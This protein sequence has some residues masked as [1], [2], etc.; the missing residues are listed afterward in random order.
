MT[1]DRK[2]LSLAIRAAIV[3]ALIP[4]F[5]PTLAFAQDDAKSEAEMATLDKVVVTA[6]KR[7]EELRDVPLSIT[8]V[9][10]AKIENLGLESINDI[11]KVSPGFSFRSAFGREGDRPVIRGQANIQGEA[12]AAFFIDGVFVNGSISGYGLDNL[13]RVEVIRGPQAALFGRRTFA[14]AV[15]FI[16]KRPTNEPQAKISLSAATN[17]DREFAANVSGA[18]V[19]DLLM[20][21]ANTRYYQ[22]GGQWKNAV[23]DINDLGGQRTASVGG[24]L[25]FTPNDWWESTL[26]MNY[27]SDQDEHY[28]IGRIG[29][30]A[31]LAARGIVVNNGTDYVNNVLTCDK[32]ALTGTTTSGFLAGISPVSSNRARGAI[33]GDAPYPTVIGINTN[34]FQQAGFKPGLDRARSRFSW[35]N[36][37]TTESGWTFSSISAYNKNESLSVVDQDYSSASVFTFPFSANGAFE[38]VDFGVSKDYSQEFRLVSP[39]DD[40]LRGIVGYYYYKE[41]Q[42]PGYT[43]DMTTFRAATGTTAAVLPTRNPTRPTGG[44]NNTALFGM[45]EYDWN[46]ALTTTAEMRLAQDRIDFSGTSSFT[47]RLAGQTTNTTIVRNFNLRAN[48]DSILPRFT[49]KYDLSDDMNVYFLAAKGNKPGGFNGSVQGANFTDTARAS[50]IAEGLDQFKEEKAYTY[51]LGFKAGFLD[52][53]VNFSSALFSIDWR[54]QQLTES[55]AVD[56]VTGLQSLTSYTKSIGKSRVNG[57]ELEADW[58][59]SENLSLTGTY[60]HLDGKIRDYFSQDFADTQGCGAVNRATGCGSAAGKKIPRVAPNQAS[61]GLRWNDTLANGW[62]YFASAQ[63]SYEGS[64]FTQIENNIKSGSC[65]DLGLRGGLNIDAHLTATLFVRNAANT[66]CVEDVLRYINPQYGVARPAIPGE[67]TSAASAGGGLNRTNLRDYAVTPGRER[68]VGI[69]ISYKF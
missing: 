17:S 27:T 64:R 3:A 10:A 48:Y 52:N 44:L 2:T 36:D 5:A 47:G 50:L 23:T 21:Q 63:F 33:C 13:E 15:N 55:R 67:S 61:L 4:A 39:A 35:A 41:Q 43:A 32:P 20:F 31:N 30:P 14:G 53:A 69:T 68:Q 46:D 38:T 12:N 19:P 6:R 60:A 7:S 56:L 9:S 18:L 22:F 57:L 58:T 8:A 24:T 59:M 40:S 54:N 42:E 66:E 11:A 25:Y 45:L 62:G 65:S 1:T 28:A 34:R 26:R 29:D 49:V 16:T 37:F 51:E